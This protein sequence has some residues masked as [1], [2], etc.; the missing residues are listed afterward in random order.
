MEMALAGQLD[1]VEHVYSGI[2]QYLLDAPLDSAS[3]T[4][5]AIRWSIVPISS[6]P[7]RPRTAGQSLV[8]TP[9]MSTASAAPPCPP[10][11][12]ARSAP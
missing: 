5:C 4:I 1:D 11:S 2:Y 12:L 3:T 6:L 7:E 8:S 9:F 10:V